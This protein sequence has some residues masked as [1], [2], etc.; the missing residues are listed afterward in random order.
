MIKYLERMQIRNLIDQGYS[1]NEISK[2]LNYCPR[3]IS[4][5]LARGGVVR[6]QGKSLKKK[7]LDAYNPEIADRNARISPKD[8]PEKLER[9]KAKLYNINIWQKK[10]TSIP[11]SVNQILVRDDH[12]FFVV[13]RGRDGNWYKNGGT[14]EE[15]SVKEWASLA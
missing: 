9:Q 7:D 14:V 8:E 11:D 5:E 1:I 12:G 15:A 6:S 2:R 13:I 4:A 3:T 10:G